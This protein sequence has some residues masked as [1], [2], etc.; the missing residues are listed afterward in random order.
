MPK[1]AATAL[2]EQAA[3][4]A[5]RLLLSARACAAAWGMC[6]KRAAY[7]VG[8][9]QERGADGDTIYRVA[10]LAG[11]S[12]LVM[13]TQR[14]FISRALGKFY[15]SEQAVA[16]NGEVVTL[17]RQLPPDTKLLT[18]LLNKLSP[19]AIPVP[20]GMASPEFVSAAVEAYNAGDVSQEMLS[21]VTTLMRGLPQAGQDSGDSA[22]VVVEIVGVET[23]KPQP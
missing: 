19:D 12:E 5:G 15:V 6:Q 20:R 17:D 21:R 18:R 16:P 14:V 10:Y 2:T 8:R 11:Q 9:G 23:E 3:Y 13:E 1:F 7:I 22:P 4:E